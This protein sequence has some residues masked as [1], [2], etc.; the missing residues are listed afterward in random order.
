V[1]PGTYVLTARATNSSGNF[2]VS[3]AVHVTVVGRPT[4]TLQPLSQAVGAGGTV[5]FNVTATGA[6]PL[7]YQ[8]SRN[9]AALTNGGNISGAITATLTFTTLTQTNTGNC[10]V[11][12]TNAG[13]SV[14]SSIA[15]LTVVM[16]PN[17]PPPILLPNGSVRFS[18]SAT[19]NLN[20][21]I[22][23]STNLVDWTA[24]T[25]IANPSGTIQFI[26]LNATNFSQRF[27]RV[28]WVP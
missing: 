14:T 18:L 13:G 9:Q 8:W 12:I 11:V 16:Q 26:D 2:G 10:T 6:A 24:L 1:A 27:Y 17:L 23:A 21:G 25:N 20:Y 3:P 5:A 7:N 15:S 28:V 4:I 19:P 22:D